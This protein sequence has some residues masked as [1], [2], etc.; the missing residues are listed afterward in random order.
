MNIHR[1]LG[2]LNAER[3]RIDRAI[4]AIEGLNS[5][6]RRR[7]RP[8]ASTTAPKKRGRRQLSA[9]TRKKLARLLKQ[10]WAQG[11]MRRKGKA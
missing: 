8:P 9:A 7:G 11:K 2:E 10:R 4:S 1:I 6:G 5:T 3:N